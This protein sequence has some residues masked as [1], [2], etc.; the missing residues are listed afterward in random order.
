MNEAKFYRKM[1]DGSFKEIG[2]AENVKIEIPKN[3]V[4]EPNLIP[5]TFTMK[6]KTPKWLLR[7]LYM[8]LRRIKI[9][10]LRKL[11]KKV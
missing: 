3:E 8:E 5:Q 2:R 1:A 6:F 11:K 7:R 10:E 9:V 4:S